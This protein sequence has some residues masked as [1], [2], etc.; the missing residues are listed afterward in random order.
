MQPP[1]AIHWFVPE[2]LCVLAALALA[3]LPALHSATSVTARIAPAVVAAAGL[4]LAWRF[5]RS[6]TVFAF[7]L[8][9]VAW[10]VIR[11]ATPTH[12]AAAQAVMLL[13]PLD[14]AAV[15]LLPERGVFTEAGLLAWGML[16]LQALVIGFLASTQ[17]PATT[18]ALR[19]EW[20]SS[21]TLAAWRI[22]QPALMAFGLAAALLLLFWILE[23][24][25]SARVFWWALLPTLLGSAST[26]AMHTAIYFATAGLVLVTGIV[27]ASYRMAYRD[28][29]TGLP[30]RRALNEA[31]E[32]LNAPAAIAM[33]DVDHFK[34][35]NDRHGHDV[36]DQVL[37]LVAAR[38][39][40]NAAGATV[41]RFGGEEFA[42]VFP[43]TT[44]T[45]AVGQ[46][47]VMRQAVEG[48][49]FLLRHRPRSPRK[50]ASPPMRRRTR[51]SRLAVTVS[52]GVALS[53]G[54][55]ERLAAALRAADQALYRAKEGGRNRVST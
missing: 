13:L 40:A 7:V 3:H 28:A 39:H 43:G 22:G 14:L 10:F 29:L 26:R 38:L 51:E 35:F 20:F 11:P 25:G 23:P 12:A 34:P 45:T 1:R 50:P 2:G 24:Q 48:A 21:E 6:R 53:D 5:H 44:V 17:G 27:E 4:L 47:E 49:V 18:A 16:G 55:P 37:R 41:Y 31:L 46:L 36:G 54:V 33:I 52:V 32:R 19:T 30:S 42:A 8:L 9:A 15:A